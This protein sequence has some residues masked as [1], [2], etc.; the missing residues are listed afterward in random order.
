M[1]LSVHT[2]KRHFRF[3]PVTREQHILVAD[4]CLRCYFPGRLS[5]ETLVE[6]LLLTPLIGSNVTFCQQLPKTQFSTWVLRFSW[7]KPRYSSLIPKSQN[8]RCLLFLNRLWETLDYT[9]KTPARCHRNPALE[10]FFLSFVWST[11]MPVAFF[12][13]AALSS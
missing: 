2:C 4:K 7:R 5:V 1:E 12:S 11:L 8:L 6:M 9:L 10:T 3:I 13:A